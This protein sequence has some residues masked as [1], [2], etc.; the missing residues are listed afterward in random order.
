MAAYQK[1]LEPTSST[2]E[3]LEQFSQKLEERHTKQQNEFVKLKQKFEKNK[4][5]I[6]KYNQL[7]KKV[8]E[9]KTL[10]KEVKELRKKR[11][12]LK[13][14]RLSLVDAFNEI[15]KK[16]YE[17]RYE[18]INKLNEKFDGVIKITLTF[19]GI[20]DD[21][22]EAL[23]EAFRGSGMRYNIIIPKIIQNFTPDRFAHIVHEKDYDTLKKVAGIDKE[24]SESIF[25]ALHETEGIYE[26]ERIY[27]QD[28][29][30]FLLKVD[31]RDNKE[32][33]DQEHFKKSEELSTGQRCT[34]VLPIIF[35]VSQNPLIIDQPEDNLD[36]KYITEK[37]HNIIREQKEERQLIFITHNPNIPVL[38]ESDH[39]LFLSYEEKKSYIDNEGSI[40][41]VKDDILKL[42]EGGREAFETRKAIYGI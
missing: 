40:D 35:E 1:C 37:I 15:K 7:S 22:E 8:D 18:N 17:V 5:Y 27:C 29:P 9:K 16:I 28:L 32:D 24:R 4:Q 13:S 21:Y 26:V 2:L 10:K 41:D 34:T 25:D 6:N 42:L 12:K 30:E 38:S 33:K 20:S 19:S 3:N 36:N 31:A 14:Y 11:D 39:N 23:K